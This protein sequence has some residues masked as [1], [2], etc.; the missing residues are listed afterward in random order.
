MA[1]KWVMVSRGNSRPTNVRWNSSRNISQALP[2]SD[3]K[4]EDLISVLVLVNVDVVVF[5]A[6]M[7]GDFDLQ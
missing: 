2:V 3:G 1:A 7:E 6:I 4:V 5:M